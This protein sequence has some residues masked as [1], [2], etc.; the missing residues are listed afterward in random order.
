MVNLREFTYRIYS[1]FSGDDGDPRKP[2]ASRNLCIAWIIS[3]ENDIWH[4]QGIVLDVKRIIGC[5]KN[6]ELKYK[7]LRRNPRKAEAL[8]S[9]SQAKL[10]VI[11]APVL[12]DRV[13]EEELRNPR[14]KRLVNLLHYFPAGAFLEYF[15][16]EH[17]DIYFQLV[18]DEIG[19]MGCEDGIREYFLKDKR[20]DWT[21][22]RPDWLLFTKSG[23]SLMLQ[24]ADI[25][26]GL[27]REYIDS[28]Q[29]VV[30]PPCTV[31]SIKGRKKCTNIRQGKNVGQTR[32][33]YI[34]YPLL[35]KDASGTAWDRGFFI[36][37]PVVKR[38][39]MFIDCF[40]GAI[41]A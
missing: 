17:P 1:D 11:I 9:L 38:E 34:L 14:T 16:L 31:C 22:S 35:L 13:R 23:S 32:L 30:L 15:A 41:W 2:G 5:R 24:L 28:L 29:D 21:V 26:A 4:N 7:S 8:A 20:L 40:F 10:K 19:W 3:A 37:P 36:R 12:K 33:M 6:A 25:F 39:Y 27:G 18:F